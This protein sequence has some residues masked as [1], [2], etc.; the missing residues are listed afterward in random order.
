METHVCRKCNTEKPISEFYFRKQAK[1]TS[2]IIHT[3]KACGNKQH[4]YNVLENM[5]TTAKSRSKQKGREF[6]ITQDDIRALRIAQNDK[7]ALTGWDLDWEPSY[8][9]KR[10]CPPT[11]ASLDRIDST[12]GYTVDNIQLVCDMANRAKAMY[13]E[14]VFVAMCCSIAEQYKHRKTV[15]KQ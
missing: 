2:G 4:A 9:G 5:I 6:S 10:V 3:C 15:I 8:D 13:T 7:C 14:D 1:R 12:R 11:R